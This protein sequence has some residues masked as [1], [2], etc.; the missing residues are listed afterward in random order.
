MST[1]DPAV[2]E[3]VPLSGLLGGAPVDPAA[4]QF[5]GEWVFDPTTGTA[6]VPAT[7][8]MRHSGPAQGTGKLYVDETTI[9]AKNMSAL[10]AQVEIS[11]RLY[12]ESSISPL[13][14]RLYA[15]LNIVDKGTY[16]EFQ[17]KPI[18]GFPDISGAFMT[19]GNY[20]MTIL[21]DSPLPLWYT[22]SGNGMDRNILTVDYNSDSLIWR[23]IDEA[24][25][26][27]LAP[28]AG[29]GQYF[30]DYNTV[31]SSSGWYPMEGTAANR[32]MSTSV[33][34]YL[35][36]E[37][38]YTNAVRQEAWDAFNGNSRRWERY[39][40]GASTWTAWRYIGPVTFAT[41]FPASPVDGMEHILV[42]SITAPTYQW[43]F[44]YVSAKATNKWVFIGGSPAIVEAASQENHATVN[45]YAALGTVINFSIPVGGDYIT[46]LGALLATGGAIGTALR[47]SYDIGATG[48]ADADALTVMAPQS[49]AGN[50]FHAFRRKKKLALSAV[51]LTVKYKTSSTNLYAQDR[52]LSITPIAVGG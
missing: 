19:S 4:G 3:W 17:T 51:T 23:P 10:F 37:A 11:A 14:W 1:P 32:P 50:G 36:V 16:Y 25:P 41:T 40:I 43:R 31:P 7:G 46:E 22:Y 44:R 33:E 18:R 15:V 12:I 13:I 9:G 6:V 28:L 52:S 39:R 8:T 30:S 34:C 35:L 42:D 5:L 45:S 48:A 2:T 20:K 49:G 29:S 27:R 26:Y 21:R 38:H 47:M 24:L